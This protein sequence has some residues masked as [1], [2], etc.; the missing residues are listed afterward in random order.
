MTDMC[1]EIARMGKGMGNENR[2]RIL[3]LVLRQ[4]QTVGQIAKKVKLAQ[5][6]VS[7]HLKSLKSRSLLS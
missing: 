1:E 5:P 2:F 4:A 6:A 7:Q 3:Q